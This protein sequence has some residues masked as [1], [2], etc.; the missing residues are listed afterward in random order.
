MKRIFLNIFVAVMALGLMSCNSDG[1]DIF[2]NNNDV[3]SIEVNNACEFR[4]AIRA[5]IT[6]LRAQ[7]DVSFEAVEKAFYQRFSTVEAERIFYQRFGMIEADRGI[8]LRSAGDVSE[9][10]ISDAAFFVV[11]E[12][13]ALESLDFSTKN[14][15]LSALDNVLRVNRNVLTDFEYNILSISLLINAEILD[16]LYDELEPITPDGFFRGNWWTSWGRCA[17]AITGAVGTGVLTGGV[18]GNAIPVL[19]AVPGMIIGGIAAGTSAAA[20]LAACNPPPARVTP[21]SVII[22]TNPGIT[23]PGGNDYFVGGGD[24]GV[25]TP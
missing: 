12:F 3:P 7:E 11:D 19:G 24:I 1:K 14:E 10:T 20:N 8:A 22:D 15:Y 13:V 18:A 21:P 2:I 16:V 5:V 23:N 6:D 25:V 4:N 17:F 9:L